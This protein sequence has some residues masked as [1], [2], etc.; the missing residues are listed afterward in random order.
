MRPS[1]F[2]AFGVL[3]LILNFPVFAVTFD[4]PPT[5]MHF[6][7]AVV[8]VFAIEIVGVGLLFLRKWAALYFSIPLF[9]FGIQEVFVS[10]SD[11]TFPLN[12]LGMLHGISLTFPLIVTIRAWKQLTWGRRFF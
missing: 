8:L 3:V 6:L 10:I 11:I 7:R 1:Y 4:Q 12:L 2:Q 9:W 5:L